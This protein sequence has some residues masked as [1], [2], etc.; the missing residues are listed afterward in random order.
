MQTL[1]D[2]IKEF[3]ATQKKILEEQIDMK[4]DMMNKLD[5]Y[6]NIASK[7]IQNKNSNINLDQYAIVQKPV[8]PQKPSPDHKEG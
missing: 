3:D 1:I 8:L 5:K 4:K 6:E 7:L 2:T